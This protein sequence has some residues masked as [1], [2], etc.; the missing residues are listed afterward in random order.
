MC[1]LG[2]GR[3][4]FY[5]NLHGEI[6]TDK[7]I[8]LAAGRAMEL[9]IG[10]MVVASETGL[11]ALRV[12]D[13]FEGEVIVA[14]SAV[15]TMVEDTV[16]GDLKIGIPDEEIYRELL[17]RGAKVVRGTD[18]LWG[19]G[20]NTD[21]MDLGKLGIMFYKVICGGVHVCISAVLEATDAGHLRDGEEVVAMAGSWVGL[22]TA[23]VAGASNSVNFFKNFEI[24]EVICKPRRPRFEWPL[25]R[26]TWRGE[27]DKYKRF[28]A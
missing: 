10:R 8:E 4:T 5:F 14:S 7:C 3:K 1:D 17:D 27:L 26:K 12:L 9:G 19:I 23:I 22:D 13:L 2:E 21:I 28:T 16:I 11:S 18:P 20:A 25:N 24:L 15:G 6:N